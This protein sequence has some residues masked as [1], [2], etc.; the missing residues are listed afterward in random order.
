[1]KYLLSIINIYYLSTY[2]L[3]CLK[4]MKK[5][6]GTTNARKGLRSN[7]LIKNQISFKLLISYNEHV[8]LQL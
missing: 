8:T 7:E 2:V 6:C 4:I 1:M 3:S 5:E